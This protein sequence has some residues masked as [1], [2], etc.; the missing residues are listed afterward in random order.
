MLA[1]LLVSDDDYK[2]ADLA[3]H[4]PPVELGHD[5]LD[6]CLHLIVGRDEHRQTIFFDRCEVF[7]RINAALEAVSRKVTGDAWASTKAKLAWRIPREGK[8]TAYF[9]AMSDFGK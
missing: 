7:S 3:M 4:H 2:L 6:V 8:E 9:V 1:R 5:L